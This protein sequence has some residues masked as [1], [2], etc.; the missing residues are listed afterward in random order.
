MAVQVAN[1]G[2]NYSVYYNILNYFKAIMKNHPSINYVSQ[3]DVF[4]V[5]NRQFPA[6]PLGN[7]LITKSVFTDSLIIHSCEL[8][9]ADKVKL[10]NNDSAPT[11]NE[12]TIPYYGTDDVVDIF[13]NTL[14]I[15][16]DLT[17]Y[18]QYSVEA[19]DIPGS[20]T[21]IPFRDRF[22]NGL[23]GHVCSFDLYAFG[24]R[25]RCLFPLLEPGDY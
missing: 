10:K 8:T 18:T 16:N 25:D 24:F 9:I 13:A 15:I 12:Q 3:G 20:I 1:Q 14:A 7:I 6:Y 23:A 11:T 21:S 22:D 4:E 2:Q 17:T 19:F 5:D